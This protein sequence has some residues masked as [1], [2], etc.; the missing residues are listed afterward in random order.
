MALIWLRIA[1]WPGCTG[2]PELIMHALEHWNARLATLLLA[3]LLSAC[4]GGGDA[5]D[6]PQPTPSTPV[7]PGAPTATG[8]TATDGFAWFNYR[9][10]QT[11]LSVLARNSAIDQAALGHS[12]YL[13]LNETV[14]HDQVR[15]KS[16]YTGVTLADRFA[17][18]NYTVRQPYAYGEVISAA[19][20]RTGFY[21]AEELIAAIYHRFVIFEPLFREMGTGASATSNGYTYFTADFAASGGYGP[22][23]GRGNVVVYPVNGQ[24]A[25]PVNFLSDSESPDPVPDRNEVGYPV[26]VHADNTSTIVVNSFTIRARGGMDLPT[27]LLTTAVDKETPKAAASIIPL[28]KLAA[29]TV[30]DVSFS[31]T[32]DGTAIARNWSFTTR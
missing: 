1:L 16:G 22:G 10:A 21:H 24:T 26:S 20:D 4:G 18:A 2:I 17:A 9:R 13:R 14:S 25:V 15:G 19:G 30:Y 11:G 12:N 3:G 7:Q 31:G 28:A 23:V 32:V 5:D 29:G 6:R 8:D 27:R